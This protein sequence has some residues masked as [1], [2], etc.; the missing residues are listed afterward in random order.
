MARKPTHAVRKPPASTKADDW[1]EGAQASRRPGASKDVRGGV[2]L[3][4]GVPSVHIN[5]WIPVEL[6]RRLA[7]YLAAH[8]REL[9]QV[10]TDALERYLGRSKK[11]RA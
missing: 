4:N 1:V 2:R 3:M 5:P 6:K 8:D 10:V 9:G 7:I 11:A